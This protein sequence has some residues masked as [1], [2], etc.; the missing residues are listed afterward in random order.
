VLKTDCG[1][2]HILYADLTIDICF[3]L[4]SP[5]LIIASLPSSSAAVT[6]LFVPHRTRIQSLIHRRFDR[7]KYDTQHILSDFAYTVRLEI[8]L[9]KLTVRPFRRGN[10]AAQER[11]RVTQKGGKEK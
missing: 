8:D 7:I 6:A 4:D 5:E 2:Q 11:P 1:D 10:I 3:S 9:E